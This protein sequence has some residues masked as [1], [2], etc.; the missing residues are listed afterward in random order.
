LG[1]ALGDHLAT[2]LGLD[3]VGVLAASGRETAYQIVVYVPPEHVDGVAAALWEAG[4]GHFGHYSEA[5]FRSAG[6]GTFRP[7]EGA[8]P[9][10]GKVGELATVD[11][12]KLEVIV[13]ERQRDEA[14]RAM[15]E[16]HPYEEVAYAVQVLHNTMRPYG[17]ARVG[18]LSD[19]VPIEAFALGV[20]DGLSAP[21]VRLVRGG[22]TVRKVACSPGASASFIAAARRAGCDVLV[23][24]DFKHHDALQAK[25]L[26]LSL[27]DVTHAATEG[28]TIQM[29]SEAMEELQ[30]VDV[31]LS[32][33]NTNP[34]EAL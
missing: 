24:G 26:G 15:L 27:V 30:N 9:T 13:P 5:S 33:T 11:E 17:P 31:V 22:P 16:A 19:E 6:T 20:R 10:V 29:L 34:F 12:I 23:G 32:A 7:L 2:H 4:A 1:H 25:A 14:V 8:H 28:A 3:N 18:E 21:G